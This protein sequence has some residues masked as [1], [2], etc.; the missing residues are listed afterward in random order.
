MVF[1]PKV[2]LFPSPLL[3]SLSAQSVGQPSR[4]EGALAKVRFSFLLPPNTETAA[5]SVSLTATISSFAAPPPNL[6]RRSDE[7]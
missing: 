7:T 6:S 2:F 3:L 5:T 4:P 1:G